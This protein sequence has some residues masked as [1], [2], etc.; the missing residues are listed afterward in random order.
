[1][2]LSGA[3]LLIACLNIANM[4]M[5]RGTAR[6]KEIAIRVAIGGGRRRIVRQL[7]T[8]SLLL[9][10]LGGAGGVVLGYGATRV[11]V[12]SLSAIVPFPL[13]LEARPDMNILLVAVAFSVLSM[14]V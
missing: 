11:V 13:H 9:A 2:P 1:M 3:V 6:R 5:A 7:V 12:S 14:L 10:N 8:E 4:F